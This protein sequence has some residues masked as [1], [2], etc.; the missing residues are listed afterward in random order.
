MAQEIFVL[1]RI[2]NLRIAYGKFCFNTIDQVL[3]FETVIKNGAAK[4]NS[5]CWYGRCRKYKDWDYTTN[6]KTWASGTL[7][8]VI[9]FVATNEEKNAIYASG[10]F[11]KKQ[12]ANEFGA[13][14]SRSAPCEKGQGGCELNEIVMNRL[15][16]IEFKQQELERNQAQIIFLH[17]DLRK[18]MTNLNRNV[19]GMFAE[20]VNQFG[21]ETGGSSSN[22]LDR[23][24]VFYTGDTSLG[25]KAEDQNPKGN[26]VDFDTSNNENVGHGGTDFEVLFEDVIGSRGEDVE[27]GGRFH[28]IDKGNKFRLIKLRMKVVGGEEPTK[29]LFEG[30]F[31]SK[32]M[33][34]MLNLGI[35]D[36]PNAN[37]IE[38]D[39]MEFTELD[40]KM[41]DESVQMRYLSTSKNEEDVDNDDD[42]ILVDDITPDIPRLRL[43][44]AVVVFK[45]PY[46]LN[47]G[48]SAKIR[49]IR[50]GT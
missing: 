34:D 38:L 42:Y 4:K 13:S 49:E 36:E 22:V 30:A 40:L 8:E 1:K 35:D 43:R 39:D 33:F 41:I 5:I 6:P 29:Y 45:S 18:E 16:Q 32:R 31:V 17:N 19:Q 15:S 20:F 14:S 44:K 2:G 26:G 21:K 9:Q 25:R 27:V 24:I 37:D 23:Q 10:L 11:H 50:T 47:F 46:T 7:L 28:L 48:S 3:L 12:K